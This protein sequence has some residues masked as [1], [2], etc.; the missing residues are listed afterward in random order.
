LAST[1]GNSSQF[2]PDTTLTH[3]KYRTDLDGLRGIAILTVVGYHVFKD[4]IQGGFIGVDIFFVLSGYLISTIIF[5]NLDRDTF[6]FKEFYSR[7]IRRIFPALLLV[8]IVCYL[9]GWFVLWAH[10]FK[11]LC[12]HIAGGAGFISNFLLWQESGYFDNASDTKPLLHLWSLGIE[13]QFYIVFPL[14]IWFAYKIRFN[15]PALMFILVS[16]SFGV[17]IAQIHSNPI[18]TFYSPV[19]RFWELIIGSLLAYFDLYKKYMLAKVKWS[20]LPDIKSVI[21][22][23]FI[24]L[25]LGKVTNESPY[26]GWWALLP[27]LGAVLFI[28]AGPQAFLNR[29]V[30]SNKLLVWFGLISYPLYLW[31]FSLLSFTRIVAGI[32]SRHTRIALVII[33]IAFSW[34]TYKLIEKP[35]RF[36]TNNKIKVTWLCL[37]MIVVGL[38]GFITYKSDGFPFRRNTPLD[39]LNQQQLTWYEPTQEC[40]SLIGLEPEIKAK[41]QVFC[42]FSGTKENFKVAILGD[43]TANALMPGLE[44][45]YKEKNEGI[46]NIGNATCAPF[47]GLN[48]NSEYNNK[49]DEVNRKAYDYVLKDPTI[50][51]VM[52]G[53]ANWDIQKVSMRKLK[54]NA[55]FD[56]QLSV[57]SLLVQE[58]ISALKKS[59]KNVVVTF[60]SLEMLKDPKDCL[61]RFFKMNNVSCNQSASKLFD[62]QPLIRNLEDLFRNKD[63]CVFHQSEGVRSGDFFKILDSDGVLL[64]R[65]DKHLSYHGSDKVAHALI[66]SECSKYFK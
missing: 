23:L 63:A 30:L 17:N 28:S 56:D 34:I 43:S 44:K 60:D 15:L 13:E 12:K 54:A 57:F 46:I 20:I 55:N 50:K 5:S 29:I 52:L 7:R 9:F 45:I 18:G 39:L 8:L 53:F 65:D 19:P 38:T 14:L 59:G 1:K 40:I 22:F 21:G 66:N 32:P 6:S 49:C 11:Q 25:A 48:G 61:N 33:S 27:T 35:I 51:T 47:R 24:S 37:L 3:P 31:H 4:R 16:I 26:P 58:D 2:K 41:A 36:G 42:S 62:R 64:F 10:E